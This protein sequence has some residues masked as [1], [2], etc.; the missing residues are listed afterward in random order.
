MYSNIGKKIKVL[1]I[2]IFGIEAFAAFLSAIALMSVDEEMIPG[3]IIILLVGPLL[4]W[5]SSWLLYGFGELIDKTCDI[6]RN[7][8]VMA[9]AT[10][11]NQFSA[12]QNQYRA[13][14]P[15]APAY[16]APVQP[17]QPAYAPPAQPAQ[18]AYAPP[19]QPA[20]PDPERIAQIERLHNQGLIDDQEYNQAIAKAQNERF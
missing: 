7:T 3:G 18:P 5:I 2:V 4:A 11:P 1:A 10:A 20:Q 19:A 14:P 17:A 12:P 15:V 13:A 16:A 8:R 9:Y 6:E